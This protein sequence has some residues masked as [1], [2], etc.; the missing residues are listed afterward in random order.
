MPGVEV[1]GHHG[2]HGRELRVAVGVLVGVA[3]SPPTPLPRWGRGGLVVGC[4]MEYEYEEWG[5]G[6]V[7]G[8]RMSA[9]SS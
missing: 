1:L 6:V 7:G 9:I 8:V 4:A 3:P 5:T 2:R